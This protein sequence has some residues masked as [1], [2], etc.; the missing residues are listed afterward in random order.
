MNTYTQKPTQDSRNTCVRLSQASRGQCK[1]TSY[2]IKLHRK[3]V[4]GSQVI[5]VARKWTPLGPNIAQP[6]AYSK[7]FLHHCGTPFCTANAYNPE[8]LEESNTNSNRKKWTVEQRLTCARQQTSIQ[9][10]CIG[11][12]KKCL[13][14]LQN[15]VRLI[16]VI[17]TFW[18]LYYT[19]AYIICSNLVF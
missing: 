15:G 3:N 2:F 10:N 7:T 14:A 18:T 12:E 11:Y 5:E 1:A 9:W 8:Q 6:T 4:L 19:I 16:C 13:V 17:I